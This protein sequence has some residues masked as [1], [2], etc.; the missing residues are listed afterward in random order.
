MLWTGFV[1][2]K[3][4]LL[5]GLL[6]IALVVQMSFFRQEELELRNA[7]E[8]LQL[9]DLESNHVTQQ[10]QGVRLVEAKNGKKEWILNASTARAIRDTG[11]WEMDLVKVKFFVKDSSTYDVV[12]DKGVLK[13]NK[14]MSING[15]VNVRSTKDMKVTTE[16]L[17]YYAGLKRLE[18]P[19]E[20]NL[21]T[22]EKDKESVTMV[23]NKMVASLDSNEVHLMDGVKTAMQENGMNMSILSS[24]AKVYSEENRAKFIE[25]VNIKYKDIRIKANSADVQYNEKGQ[26]L[27]TVK[28]YGRVRL[29]AK[30]K[31]A[32]SDELTI[33]LQNERVEM[34]GQPVLIQGDSEL[35][36]EKIVFRSK[37]NKIEIQ[38]AK[39]HLKEITKP[40]VLDSGE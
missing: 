22:K 29:L 39:A 40:M 34:K 17:N 24:K 23:A 5:I 9:S 26:V 38:R 19:N 10:M 13:A 36:G 27:D 28:A 4:L 15:D 11:D 32:K 2:D 12:G 7:D 31:N 3:G 16:H 8:F 20:L 30:E 35:L 25:D 33:F 6:F 37:T 1:R 14:D 18:A 21:V